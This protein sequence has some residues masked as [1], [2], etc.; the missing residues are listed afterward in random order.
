M[1]KLLLLSCLTVCV[2]RGWAGR[3]HATL[4][5]P[6]G[7][8][9]LPENAATP[10]RRVHAVLGGIWTTITLPYVN[11]FAI[12]K[13]NQIVNKVCDFFDISLTIYNYVDFFMNRIVLSC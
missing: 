8:R 4:P 3:D 9:N 13:H 11:L 5:E 12:K 6:A 10:T 1:I 2:T 7:A